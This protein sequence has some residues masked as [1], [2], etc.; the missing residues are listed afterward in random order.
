M[1][2]ASCGILITLSAAIILAAGACR[3][4]DA[5]PG[6][7]E[8][9]WVADVD[10]LGDTITVRTVSGSAWG[11]AR[12]VEELRVGQLDGSDQST[13][14][15]IGALEVGAGGELLVYESQSTELRRY[16]ADGR[17]LGVIGRK[18]S[19]PGEYENIS[20]LAVLPDGRLVVQDFGNRRLN[21]YD[22]AYALIATWPRFTNAAELRPLYVHDGGSTYLYDWAI[23]TERRAREKILV[24][25]D[26]E[27]ALG[28]TILIPYADFRVPGIELPA[29]SM[30]AP[31]PFAAESHW[32]VTRDGHII[33]AIGDRYAV[34]I[35]RPTGGVLRLS[36]AAAPVA[37]SPDERAAEED[38]IARIFRRAVPGWTWDGPPIPSTKPPIMWIHTGRD[39]SIW[40]RVP[41]PGMA[42]PD[43]ARVAGLQSFVREPMAFDVFAVDGRYLGQ[44]TA[45]AGLQLQPYPVIDRDRVWAVV[46][47][48]DG[49]DVV[50]R[51]RIVRD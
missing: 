20:G 19:G 16:G 27:G 18:G 13:F 39:S 40:V 4:H 22:A 43:S 23:N 33:A 12:L 1:H 8:G 21:V 5:G 51:F 38:R 31:L 49:V 47:G 6:A 2:R 42:L 50:V 11:T 30:G 44:V 14:G 25:L 17:F 32:S 46:H 15:R 48:A 45:P 9:P 3:A 29:Q 37:V 36:R 26:R 34:D 24:R 35:M 28:D 10:T 7:I 41:Q